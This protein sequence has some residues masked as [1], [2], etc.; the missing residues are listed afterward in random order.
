MPTIA[1]ITTCKED[2]GGS[3]ELWARSIPTLQAGGIG[4]I[5]YKDRINREHPRWTG[6][7]KA[8]VRLKELRTP[9]WQFAVRKVLLRLRG[10]YWYKGNEL[11]SAFTRQLRADRP[12][13]V[14]IAQGIN[15][16]G[17]DYAQDCLAAG[18]PYVIICQKAVDFYWPQLD[19]RPGMIK[20]F[21][22]AQ[23]CFFVSRHNQQLTEEQFGIRLSNTQLIYNP[24]DRS[25]GPIPYPG[26]NSVYRL[27]CIGRLFVL[28]KGQDILIRLLSRPKWR[29]RPIELVFVGS[30]DDR[31]GLEAMA[32]L[33][34]LENIH[35]A[36]QRND[37]RQLWQE[38]HALVLPSRSEGLPL[39][40]LEA[41]AAGR[42]VITTTAGGSQE[43]IEDGI[44]GFIGESGAESFDQALERAWQRR[45]EWQAMGA[46]ACNHLHN[47]L[48]DRPAEIDFAQTLIALVHDGGSR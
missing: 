40:V 3:E 11:R 35:F 7:V 22:H 29:E 38:F 24:V 47:R 8:G 2:W 33:H 39:V 45:G 37:M 23:R 36:G 5:V 12:S 48:P 31:E 6:L 32:R 14:V 15:F 20:A 10:K 43:M 13:L 1:I 34:G 42:V 27:A 41:M 28:D 18:V 46:A 9:T 4:V 17:L 21:L 25:D 26:G 30:G 16:D 19:H 44:T